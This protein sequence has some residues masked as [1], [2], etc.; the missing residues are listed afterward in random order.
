MVISDNRHPIAT[1]LQKEFLKRCLL[2][3]YSLISLFTSDFMPDGFDVIVFRFWI[4]HERSSIGFSGGG[5]YYTVDQMA[6]G[7]L[8]LKNELRTCFLDLGL[9]LINDYKPASRITI[10]DRSLLI[11]YGLASA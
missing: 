5:L 3:R 4:G 6:L 11:G 9:D 1:H 8:W 7:F 2:G 10:R